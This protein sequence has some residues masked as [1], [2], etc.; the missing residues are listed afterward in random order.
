MKESAAHDTNTFDTTIPQTERSPRD[1]F[2]E[3]VACAS[4]GD[5]RAIGAI[6]IAIGPT[7]LRE[8]RLVLGQFDNEADD[9]LQDFFLFLVERRWPTTPPQDR[10]MHWMCVIVRTIA[11]E[12][13]REK[14]RRWG[15]D[16][17]A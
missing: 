3:L 7:L 4:R 14:E 17:E 1:E 10:A 13:R 16:D 11:I 2:D 5:R 6:A 12:R 8:A 9:V 15:G